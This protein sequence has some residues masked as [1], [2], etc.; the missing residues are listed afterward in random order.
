MYEI[1]SCTSDR[2]CRRVNESVNRRSIAVSDEG[3]YQSIPYQKPAVDYPTPRKH[4]GSL[5]MN[6]AA[7]STVIGGGYSC[8]HCQRNFNE[9]AY[10]M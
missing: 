3:D 10:N 6:E 1:G 9:K 5:K 4:M 8:P 2:P 7:P